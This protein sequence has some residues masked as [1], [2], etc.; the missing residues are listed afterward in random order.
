MTDSYLLTRIFQILL[1]WTKREKHSYNGQSDACSSHAELSCQ[2]DPLCP[3]PVC[4]GPRSEEGTE[5]LWKATAI[6]RRAPFF[7]PGPRI[8]GR[9][10]FLLVAY[11]LLLQEHQ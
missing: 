5:I 3:T 2:T 9:L 6:L 8:P 11:Y 4:R 10:L 7:E 1:F